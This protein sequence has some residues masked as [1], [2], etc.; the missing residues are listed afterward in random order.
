MSNRPVKYLQTDK[1][2]GALDYSAK[3]EKTN[4]AKSGCGPTCAAM[5]IATLKDKSVTPKET[6]AWSKKHRSLPGTV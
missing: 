5:V 3:G 1:R 6:A 4:I 2:W